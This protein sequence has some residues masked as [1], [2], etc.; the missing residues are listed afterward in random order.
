MSDLDSLR[1][2]VAAEHGLDDRAVSFLT[3]STLAEVEESAARLVH[4]LGEHEPEAPAAPAP[5]AADLFSGAAARKAAQQQALL[6]A[7]TGRQE[8]DRDERGRFASSGGFDGG[9][10]TPT[11]ARR[12]PAREHGELVG[13]MA[14]VTRM[15]GLGS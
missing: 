7:L 1:A 13:R 2:A 11:R 3:G 5:A 15:F 8:Q 12:D 10:R 4:L 6:N 14:A 9:A